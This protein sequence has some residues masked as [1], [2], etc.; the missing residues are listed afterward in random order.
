MDNKKEPEIPYYDAV[1]VEPSG[2]NNPGPPIPNG[3]S[4]SIMTYPVEQLVGDALNAPLSIQPFLGNANGARFR[5]SLLRRHSQTADDNSRVSAGL[6][7]H[8]TVVV[9]IS[10]ND[11]LDWRSVRIG[12]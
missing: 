11:G 3:H 1:P 2:P 9:A 12:V 8:G 6:S 4:R 7:I 10:I 5:K